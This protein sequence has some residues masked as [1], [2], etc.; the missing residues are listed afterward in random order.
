MGT[1]PSFSNG[2]EDLCALNSIPHAM[3]QIVL[4]IDFQK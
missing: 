3:K 1:S 4:A 2:F